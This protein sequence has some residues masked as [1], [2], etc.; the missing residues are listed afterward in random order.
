M[1]TISVN[2]LNIKMNEF[3]KL[4]EKV[5]TEGRFRKSSEVIHKLDVPMFSIFL[6]SK[7]QNVKNMEL[8][9]E[10]ARAFKE[11]KTHINKIGF[12]S[13]HVNAVFKKSS[14]KDEAGEAFGDPRK[15]KYG[16][17]KNYKDLKYITLDTKFLLGLQLKNKQIY[18]QLVKTII[19]EWGHIWMFNKGE[20]FFTAIKKFY[21][22]LTNNDP[23]LKN[24]KALRDDLA[25]LIEFPRS[26]GLKDYYE[27][28]AVMVERFLDLNP[29]YRK[30]IFELMDTNEPRWEPNSRQK[31]ETNTK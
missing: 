28:W 14:D 3:D 13:M 30:K 2:Q 18:D 16:K 22:Q 27:M 1:N 7:V 26:Y 10:V 9:N 8:W 24:D 20:S 25:K 17:D 19:H 15:K 21:R 6:D 11:A 12:Q 29:V 31:K 5:L 23:K 4:F